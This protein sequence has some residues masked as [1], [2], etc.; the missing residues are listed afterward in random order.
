M[1]VPPNIE[2][3]RIKT[4]PYRSDPS[5]GCNGMFE[6][7]Y[8]S[9]TLR[10]IISNEAGWDHVSVSLPN[11]C[12]NWKEMCFIKQLFWGKDE[13]V[14]QFHP[15]ESEYINFN[16]NVLHMWKKQDQEYDLPPWWMIGPK[17][18]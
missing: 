16:P 5:F 6:I 3:L 11:R 18:K 9:F 4:G 2:E 12:P 15:K 10:V 7:P 8:E 17:G 1:R 13:T 14:I